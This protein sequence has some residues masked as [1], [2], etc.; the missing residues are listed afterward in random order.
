MSVEKRNTK[1]GG[2]YVKWYPEGRKKP[3]KRIPFDDRGEA[4]ECDNMLKEREGKAAVTVFPRLEQCLDDYLRWAKGNLAPATYSTRERRLEKYL[5]PFFGKYRVADLSQQILDQ[6][7][8]TVGHCTYHTDLNALLALIAWMRKR[9][10]CDNV[11]HFTPERP[12]MN[13]RKQVFPKFER[14][15][16]AIE[17]MEKEIHRVMFYLMLFNALRWNEVRNIL[18]ENVH[19]NDGVYKLAET[20]IQDLIPIP[21]PILPWLK[22]NRKESGPVFEGRAKGQPY[23]YLWKVW[24]KAGETIGLRVTSHTFRRCAANHLYKM[25]GDIHLVQRLLRHKKVQTTLRYIEQS[26]EA[27]ERGVTMLTNFAT[28]QGTMTTLNKFGRT[29]NQSQSILPA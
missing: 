3:C 16:E 22:A 26:A 2:Y 20:D 12:K 1:R 15:I 27:A 6:Y 23:A 4:V 13:P 19:L 8:A 5:I 29:S 14:M 7:R 24:L 28:Q 10:Y 18:W 21:A 11:L 25:T 17:S 9:G